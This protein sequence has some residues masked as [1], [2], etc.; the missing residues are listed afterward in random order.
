MFFLAVDVIILLVAKT[1]L[2]QAL[3]FVNNSFKEVRQVQNN[4]IRRTAAVHGIRLWQIAEAYGMADSTFSKLLR[5]E[6]PPE[7]KQEVLAII[8]EIASHNN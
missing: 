1:I 2:L 5:R 8:D 4:D 6:L 3:N 7:K